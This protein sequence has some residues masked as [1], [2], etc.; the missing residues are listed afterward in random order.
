MVAFLAAEHGRKWSLR[1]V[2]L[3]RA[4]IRYLHF[5]AGCPIPSAK[6]HV[7]E[8]FAGM[9]RDPADEGEL[10]D[11][12]LAATASILR[13]I[14]EQNGDDPA[15]LRDKALLTVGFAGA[16]RRAELAAIR[17][18]HLDVGDRGLRLTLPRSKGERS[19]RAVPVPLPYGGTSLCPVRALLRWQQAAEITEG[20]LFRRVWTPP[21]RRRG[22]GPLPFPVIG[23][24]PIDSGSVARIIK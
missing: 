15:G 12:K 4:S 7:A 17:V 14:I 3:R 6:A 10:P 11:K 21:T 19:R 13:E 16:L 9:R 20:P 24:E 8:T 23:T 22:D 2:D 5:I 18:D 1:A